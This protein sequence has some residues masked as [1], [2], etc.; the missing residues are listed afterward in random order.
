MVSLHERASMIAY[1]QLAK[2][3][4]DNW[5]K[6]FGGQKGTEFRK[7]QVRI[8]AQTILTTCG[9]PQCNVKYKEGTSFSGETDP[10]DWVIEVE[11]EYNKSGITLDRFVE[12]MKTAYHECRHIEQMYR[13]V[14]AVHL[15]FIDWNVND[16]M[17][18]KVAKP[19]NGQGFKNSL[20]IN[21]VAATHAIN[22]INTYEAFST[23][24][25]MKHC[26][27]TKFKG[28]PNDKW[29]NTVSN[30]FDLMMSA[31]RKKLYVQTDTAAQ[32]LANYKNSELD[33]DTFAVEALLYHYMKT[34]WP[35]YDQRKDSSR[36]SNIFP[37]P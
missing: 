10:G 4:W 2:T 20:G 5:N 8:C 30:W 35:N 21:A 18:K 11:G 1:A 32:Y 29:T 25:S 19:L 15:G 13:M 33:K 34:L 3:L 16:E 9:I 6:G 31:S 27:I 26:V 22:H 37:Q 7:A 14:Q 17:Y 12:L 24:N 28:R 36:I 23:S